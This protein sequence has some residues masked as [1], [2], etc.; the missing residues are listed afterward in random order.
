MLD[1]LDQRNKNPKPFVWTASA[2]MI[3]GKIQRLAKRISNS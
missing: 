3:L 1:Y 2:E